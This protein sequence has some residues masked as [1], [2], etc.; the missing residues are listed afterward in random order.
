MR[1]GCNKHY[2]FSPLVVR[3]QSD[4]GTDCRSY[5]CLA[6]LISRCMG[7]GIAAII[8]YPG[9]PIWSMGLRFTG[10]TTEWNLQGTC[11][12]LSEG[13]ELDC[14][15]KVRRFII[16]Y[17][18]FDFNSSQNQPAGPCYPP[19][20]GRLLRAHHVVAYSSLK[21]ALIA[22]LGLY[23]H[24]A[25]SHHAEEARALESRQSTVFQLPRYHAILT[26]ALIAC[27]MDD[28]LTS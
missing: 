15:G 6:D 18:E 12:H 7:R 19:R 5:Q 23:S 16:A 27:Q 20:H 24:T 8:N 21:N 4:L 3:E 1:D 25:S 2:P 9:S 11:F 13:P 22:I 28:S 26:H 17:Q 10:L 14:R